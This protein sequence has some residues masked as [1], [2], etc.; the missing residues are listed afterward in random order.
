[1]SKTVKLRS[2]DAGFN[3]KGTKL[4]TWPDSSQAE[5]LTYGKCVV[6]KYVYFKI[7]VFPSLETRNRHK[8]K[9]KKIKY[10]PKLQLIK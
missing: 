8:K 6:Q 1:M 5:L 7:R 4:F 9:K 2:K 3:D 10:P